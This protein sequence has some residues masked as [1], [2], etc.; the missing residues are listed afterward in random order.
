[1]HG[2]DPA[3]VEDLQTR[4]RRIEG[5]ARGLQKMLAEGRSCEDIL[6]QLSALRAAVSTVAS[7]LLVENLEACLQRG[8][9][10]EALAAVERAKKLFSTFVK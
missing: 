4:L 9:D 5:Q 1:V 8:G 3:V 2:L 7:L 10:P 6:T